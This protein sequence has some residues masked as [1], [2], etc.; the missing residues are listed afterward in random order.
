MLNSAK[1]LEACAP[2]VFARTWGSK[3]EPLGAFLAPLL[4]ACQ[5]VASKTDT[6]RRAA[7]QSRGGQYARQKEKLFEV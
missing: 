6:A 4:G 1:T 5:E 2:T 3:G 7:R